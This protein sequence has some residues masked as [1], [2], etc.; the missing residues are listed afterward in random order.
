VSIIDENP[1][2]RTQLDLGDIWV[3]DLRRH[4]QTRITF[5]G[6]SR[7]PIWS[8]DGQSLVYTSVTADE[9]AQIYSVPADGSAPP[10]LV[11]AKDR[12]K[13]VPFPS[14]FSRDGNVLAVSLRGTGR[15]GVGLYSLREPNSSSPPLRPLRASDAEFVTGGAQFSPDGRWVAYQSNRT[16]RPQVYVIAYPDSGATWQVSNDGG[17]LP[18]W[19]PNGGELFYRNGNKMMTVTI[20]TNPMFRAH[21]PQ[22][23]FEGPYEQEF[24]VSPDGKHFLMLKVKEPVA[25]PA[26][27]D[28]MIV[29]NWIDELR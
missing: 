23:L 5:E 27:S 7:N 4:L 13:T 18:K 28:L 12:D 3:F 22:F 9:N 6:R 29:S 26:A 25:T 17:N 19:S 20:E 21:P 10:E 15:P 14:A 16:G 2:Q 1:Q 11:I 8:R 24:D